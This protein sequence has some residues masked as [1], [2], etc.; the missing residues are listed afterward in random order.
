MP[1]GDVALLWWSVAVSCGLIIM[2]GRF[3]AL[4]G[5]LHN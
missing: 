3:G 2:G 4:F 1:Y 5:S